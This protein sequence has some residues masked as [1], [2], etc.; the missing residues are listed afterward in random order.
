MK[1]HD[2]P[3]EWS[4]AERALYMRVYRFMVANQGAMCNPTAAP[5][6]PEH[7]DTIAHN[8][9]W[10]AADLRDCESLRILDADTEEVV[11]ESPRGL[12]S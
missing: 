12:N 8:C 7:W 4:E 2:I 10:V 3:D 1:T 6:K 9:A 5:I 11:A